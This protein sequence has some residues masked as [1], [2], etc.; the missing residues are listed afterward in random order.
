[1][2][3]FDPSFETIKKYANLVP[4]KMHL[5]IKSMQ[6]KT[7]M[8]FDGKSVR[9]ENVNMAPFADHVADM[10]Y[11]RVMVELKKRGIIE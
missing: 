4:I 11:D 5:C 7:D 10:G 8:R 6:F 9:A 2:G 3:I 1:M